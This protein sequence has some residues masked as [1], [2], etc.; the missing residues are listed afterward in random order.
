MKPPMGLV[1]PGTYFG[2]VP[3]LETL[4]QEFS[5]FGDYRKTLAAGHDGLLL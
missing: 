4:S 3:Q 2:E 5:L 1:F